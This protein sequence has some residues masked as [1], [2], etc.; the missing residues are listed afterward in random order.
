MSYKK[1]SNN[2]FLSEYNVLHIYSIKCLS[3]VFALVW[4]VGSCRFIHHHLFSIRF[5]HAPVLGST[6]FSLWF[7]VSCL[8]R[9]N[10]KDLSNLPWKT[11][12]VTVRLKPET[13]WFVAN[14]TNH[15]ATISWWQMPINLRSYL[16]MIKHLI[17]LCSWSVL[18]M[19]L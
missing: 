3:N 4:V 6:K 10:Y 18:N 17:N 14:S 19:K 12:G 13:L 15:S 16:V 5:V 11:P 7:T 1:C 9:F 8:K 2:L